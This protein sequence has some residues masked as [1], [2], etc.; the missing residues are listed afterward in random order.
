MNHLIIASLFFVLG[1]VLGWYLCCLAD[2]K[3]ETW[4]VR[5]NTELEN[6]NLELSFELDKYLSF[7]HEKCREVNNLQKELKRQLQAT[8]EA[9]QGAVSNRQEAARLLSR[10]KC[11]EL[12]LEIE[13]N[14]QQEKEKCQD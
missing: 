11:A 6:K 7:S 10:A 5:K 13:V 4:V 9:S 1:F 3:Y 12:L 14:K 8:L 2:D